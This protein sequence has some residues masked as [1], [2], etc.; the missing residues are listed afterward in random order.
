MSHQP[1]R[2]TQRP[3]STQSTALYAAG[4]RRQG[5][6]TDEVL[7]ARP[8]VRVQVSRACGGKY[9][10]VQRS[11]GTAEQQAGGEQSR[12]AHTDTSTSYSTMFGAL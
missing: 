1:V 10:A 5:L 3:A 8:R 7:C 4:A 12:C 2:V 11:F 6:R 9:Y